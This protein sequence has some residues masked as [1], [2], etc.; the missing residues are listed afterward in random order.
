MKCKQSH[1]KRRR[2]DFS[3]ER[4]LQKKGYAL[5]V[6]I[7][8]VGRGPLAGPV[9]AACVGFNKAP[10]IRG[11]N[12]SKC[13]SAAAREHLFTVITNRAACWSIASVRVSTIDRKNI[14]QATRMAMLRAVRKLPYMPD[15]LLIDGS[16]LHVQ[17]RIPEKR[18]P[19]GDKLVASIAAASVIA[20]VRRDEI[21][22]AFDRQYSQYQFA[23]HKGYGTRLH[24][25][26]LKHHGPS[27]IHR[28]SFR[29]VAAMAFD[30]SLAKQK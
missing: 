22:R 9:V 14:F 1:S 25:E 19:G 13:L 30:A 5:V 26:C 10:R 18:I 3:R 7:D 21:M 12:D 20:K 4:F 29:P 11:L 24:L 15:Y 16:H 23:K 8:E 27:P 6:G 17:T 28:R 2:P